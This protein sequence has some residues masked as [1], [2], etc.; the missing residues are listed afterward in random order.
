M[1]DI[2]TVENAVTG[3][4]IVKLLYLGYPLLG[5][6]TAAGI[7]IAT[8]NVISTPCTDYCVRHK[9]FNLR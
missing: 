1:F 8:G 5:T 9:I 6:E 4:L 7:G 2:L 3:S